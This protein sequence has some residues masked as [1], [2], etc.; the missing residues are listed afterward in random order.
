M[1][2]FYT[3]SIAR[4]GQP[5]KIELAPFVILIENAI[6]K[7]CKVCSEIANGLIVMS[8]VHKNVKIISLKDTK[9]GDGVEARM[10]LSEKQIDYW[11]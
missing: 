2:N 3:Q 9:D 5:I 10:R 1:G 11:C 8:S 7:T 4:C 6:M